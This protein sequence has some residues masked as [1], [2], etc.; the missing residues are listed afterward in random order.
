MLLQQYSFDIEYR[1]GA[2]HH[3]ADTLHPIWITV[4]QPMDHVIR[5]CADIQLGSVLGP[6]LWSILYDGVLELCL[7]EGAKLSP[8]CNREKGG[9]SDGD[10]G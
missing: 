1:K 10:C 8:G 5:G 2:L 7:P 4:A 9:G 6:I 3:L